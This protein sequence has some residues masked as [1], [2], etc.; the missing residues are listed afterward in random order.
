MPVTE[1]L[2]SDANGNQKSEYLK[3]IDLKTSQQQE[4]HVREKV[5][6][7]FAYSGSIFAKGNG[8]H[9]GGIVRGDVYESPSLLNASIVLMWQ[10]VSSTLNATLISSC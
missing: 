6:T 8:N 3:S 2:D 7:S 10:T 9:G 4:N 1:Q 5:G